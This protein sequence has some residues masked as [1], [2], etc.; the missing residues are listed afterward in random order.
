MSRQMTGMMMTNDQ[1]DTFQSQLKTYQDRYIVLLRQIKLLD[2]GKGG[3][4]KW[5]RWRMERIGSKLMSQVEQN[6]PEN[7]LFAS[8]SPQSTDD[9]S[10]HTS[11][12]QSNQSNQQQFTSS[13]TAIS[14]V[15]G[16]IN[17]GD[18]DDIDG[19]KGDGEVGFD[20]KDDDHFHFNG[21]NG[22]HHPL[23]SISP[24]A[25]HLATNNSRHPA[26]SVNDKNES[27]TLHPSSTTMVKS[28]NSPPQQPS[29]SSITPHLSIQ[30]PNPAS[31]PNDHHQT[32]T[33]TTIATLDLIQMG[34]IPFELRQEA[35]SIELFCLLPIPTTGLTPG[36]I[37][38]TPTLDSYVDGIGGENGGQDPTHEM[39]NSTTINTSTTSP[40]P[41][42]SP[43]PLLHFP[44][45]N[46]YFYD[47]N[48][49][50]IPTHQILKDNH[51]RMMGEIN[52]NGLL[53]HYF[54]SCPLT[55]P[56]PSLLSS[57]TASSTI[58]NT[59]LSNP[60]SY[61]PSHPYPDPYSTGGNSRN[62]KY[63]Y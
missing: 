44:I 32:H 42:L 37:A 1:F 29:S 41:T 13:Q 20:E 16:C 27:T 7:P 38:S 2:R 35:K 61:R 3:V 45:Q 51:S 36:M 14:S 8:L 5:F 57:T 12:H 31:N 62:Q 26:T 48:G 6:H 54:T 34:D 21:S 52:Q 59:C 49:S 53:S 9:E 46:I 30:I 23:S 28:S 10:I 60:N 4:M 11:D 43:H 18:I 50:P 19:G 33:Q 39:T 17:H 24:S 47:R 56:T 25:L 22:N 55:N 58:P 15:S 40:S 63:V